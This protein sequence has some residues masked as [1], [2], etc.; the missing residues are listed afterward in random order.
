MLAI[1]SIEERVEVAVGAV[2]SRSARD[3]G[4]PPIFR[5][6]DKFWL[7][8]PNRLAVTRIL[9]KLL[10][11]QVLKFVDTLGREKSAVKL[12]TF[13]RWDPSRATKNAFSVQRQY[14]LLL[15]A[16]IG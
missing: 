12:N 10:L 3:F 7:A 5:S 14:A 15:F 6:H 2:C 13:C 16:H 8:V 9:R 11:V 1:L 4:E